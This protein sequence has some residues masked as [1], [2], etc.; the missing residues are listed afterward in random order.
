MADIQKYVEDHIGEFHQKRIENLKTLKLLKLIK[1]KNPYLF[2]AK[3]LNTAADIV[4]VLVDAHLS[5]QEETMFGD[6]LEGLAI[7][8]N[9]KV[10]GGV[11]AAI[12][13]IDLDFSKDGI[14]YLVTIK[15]GPNWGNS[16]QINKMKQNFATAQRILMTSGARIHVQFINGCCYGK[17]SNPV[18]SGYE[19]L[20]GQRFWE[21]ISGM[22][23]LYIDIIEPLGHKAKL[24][25]DEFNVEYGKILNFFTKQFLENFCKEDGSLDWEKIAIINSSKDKLKFRMKVVTRF[26][27]S[28]ETILDEGST[29]VEGEQESEATREETA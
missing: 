27:T 12:E 2:K 13:G 17:D 9:N 19:K 26:G 5:S 22:D 10:Y 29:P 23:N 7:Y 14:R 8:I 1:R 6:F 15:S 16:S 4:K 18:K 20:C 24:R 3:N 11:K 25:N 28:S 21:L